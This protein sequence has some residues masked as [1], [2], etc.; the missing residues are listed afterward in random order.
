MRGYI[1]RVDQDASGALRVIDYKT[2]ST[3]IRVNDLD[4]GVRLQLPLYALALRDAASLGAVTSG[5][6]WHVGSAKPSSLRLEKYPGG[7]EAALD[8][9]AGY[10]LA[11]ASRALAGDFAPR[12]PEG[13]CPSWCPATAFCWRYQPKRF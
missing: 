12:P 13:G 11:H 2:G 5:F 1:D 9:A 8:V 6:Y 7:A 3:P 4:E 10:A